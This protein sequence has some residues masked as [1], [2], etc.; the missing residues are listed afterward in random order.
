MERAL[1]AMPSLRSSPRIRSVPQCVLSPAMVAISSRTSGF[2]RGRPRAR[3]ERQR[4]KRR[5]PQRCQL[6]TVSGRTGSRGV[7]SPG[8]CAGRGA[9]ELVPNSEARTPLGTEG[10]L[11]LLAEKQVLH[12]EA[13][14]AADGGDEGGQDEPDEFEHRGRIADPMWPKI[15]KRPFAPLQG[16]EF[17]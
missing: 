11:E 10:N 16:A 3:P 14:T 5:Q 12:D 4:Q 13:L 17:V 8:A 9:K 6:S 1:T 7:A 15:A 2:S